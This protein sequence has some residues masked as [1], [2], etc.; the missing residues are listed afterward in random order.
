MAVPAA[1]MSMMEGM[2]CKACII[3]RVSSQSDRFSG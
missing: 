1:I 3:T 2:C